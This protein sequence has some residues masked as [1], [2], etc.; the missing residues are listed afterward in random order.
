MWKIERGRGGR[1]ERT[2][3]EQI[4]QREWR[5][6]MTVDEGKEVEGKGD[7]KKK[8]K[9]KKKIGKNKYGGENCKCGRGKI[10]IK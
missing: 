3:G 10:R 1:G 8:K 7:G 6:N 4:G 2:S 5:G 9:K